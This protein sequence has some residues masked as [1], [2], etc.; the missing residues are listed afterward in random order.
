MKNKFSNLTTL[1]LFDDIKAF[2]SIFFEQIAQGLSRLRILEVYNS[3][4]QQERTISTKNPVEFTH[5]AVLI[6]Y[7]RR[8]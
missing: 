6:L 1:L 3:L 4:E 5:L 7:E 8:L 2:E